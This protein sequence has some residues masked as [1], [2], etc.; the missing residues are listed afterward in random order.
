MLEDEAGFVFRDH[1]F[2]FTLES[3]VIGPVA[4]D[5][6]MEMSYS[7]SLPS[8]PQG[9]FVDVDNNGVDNLG[10]QVFAV[11]YWSNT[12]GDP[13]LEE[14][15]GKGWSTAY[16]SAVTDPENDNEIIG[17]TLVVWSPDDEQ[18]FPNDFGPDGKLFTEDDPI[19][20]VLAGYTLVNLDS[21][22]F[23]FY[24][25]SQPTLTLLEGA[26]AVKDFSKMQYSQA[27][28][29][30]YSR[31]S[32][33]YPFT[34]EKQIDWDSLHDEFLPQID[35]VQS[36]KEFYSLMRSFSYRIPDGHVNLSLDPELFYASYGGGYGITLERLSDQRVIV[37]HIVPNGPADRA[38]I[39]AGAEIASWNGEPINEAIAKVIPGFGSYST[40]HTQNLA[41]V[42]FLTRTPPETQVELRFRNPEFW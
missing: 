27:F 10:L 23:R 31:V 1:E 3:Q 16:T 4:L 9:T 26:G 22:P 37:K 29:E 25:E 38:R 11:A 24:K 13:F 28:E 30:L 40:E 12:W 21:K 20:T 39:L 14:R 36:D 5:E 33:E 35:R 17:G 42:T 34:Q 6:E 8:V 41:Q 32:L 19:E 15:D 2:R 18:G 7:L